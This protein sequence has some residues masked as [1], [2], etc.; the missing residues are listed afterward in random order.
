MA[1]LGLLKYPMIFLFIQ[2]TI[3]KRDNYRRRDGAVMVGFQTKVVG[4][5]PVAA[6]INSKRLM[7]EARD[8]QP[9]KCKNA[10]W[11]TKKNFKNKI[12]KCSR[13]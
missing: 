12:S 8:G 7:L 9:L 2:I 13:R 5:S 11:R 10:L 3:V 1:H 4:L 6:F